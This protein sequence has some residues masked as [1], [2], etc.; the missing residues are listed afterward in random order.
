MADARNALPRDSV[1]AVREERCPDEYLLPLD[2]RSTVHAHGPGD[3]GHD[4]RQVR[5]T[6]RNTGSGDRQTGGRERLRVL[7]RRPAETL[8]QRVAALHQRDGGERLGPRTGRRRALRVRHARETVPR[9]QVRP[10]QGPVQQRPAGAYGKSSQGRTA[11]RLPQRCR[12]TCYPAPEQRASAGSR[13]WQ[14]AVGA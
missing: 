4:P 2:G 10:G 8:P 14:S 13:G 5:Q 9:V 6:A 12:Q 1:L 3:V 11:D 7:Y